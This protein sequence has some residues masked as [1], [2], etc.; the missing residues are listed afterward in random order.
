MKR[1]KIFGCS[2]SPKRQA[3]LFQFA[4]KKQQHKDAPLTLI[5]H[6]QLLQDVYEFFHEPSSFL[7]SL[8]IQGDA[9]TGKRMCVETAYNMLPKNHTMLIPFNE[10]TSELTGCVGSMDLLTGQQRVLLLSGMDEHIST[11]MPRLVQEQHCRVIWL[12]QSLPSVVNADATFLKNCKLIRS[13]PPT[14]HQLKQHPWVQYHLGDQLDKLEQVLK[15]ENNNIRKA[16]LTLEFVHDVPVFSDEE[17]QLN[18][19]EDF[20]SLSDVVT[21]APITMRGWWYDHKL[22]AAKINQHQHEYKNCSSRKSAWRQ[23][24][25]HI[26]QLRHPRDITLPLEVTLRQNREKNKWA[27]RNVFF[28]KRHHYPAPPCNEPPHHFQLRGKIAIQSPIIVDQSLVCRSSQ[29]AKFNRCCYDNPWIYVL[30]YTTYAKPLHEHMVCLHCHKQ[31]DVF[32]ANSCP[33]SLKLKLRQ[34]FVQHRK[35]QQY[36]QSTYL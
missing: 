27:L 9:G 12:C 30:Q 22:F 8:L 28:G 13:T 26:L 32:I 24:V 20:M 19:S 23:G 31:Q 15:Q 10:I 1:P 5:G 29:N 18:I 11:L 34:F 36:L 21:C 33:K 3:N 14:I 2:K 4:V 7:Q 25:Q 6:K 35:Y 16:F 17:Q